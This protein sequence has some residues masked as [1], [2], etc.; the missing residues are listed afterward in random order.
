M[1]VYHQ[2]HSKKYP[3]SS[4][5]RLLHLTI[6]STSSFLYDKN[7]FIWNNP[8]ELDLLHMKKSPFL[9]TMNENYFLK[10]LPCIRRLYTV[11]NSICPNIYRIHC[12]DSLRVLHE[13]ICLIKEYLH[14][15][16]P[17]TI[18]INDLLSNEKLLDDFINQLRFSPSYHSYRNIHTPIRR[19]EIRCFGQ[20]IE[21]KDSNNQLNE[22]TLFCFE[23]ISTKDNEFL[24]PIDVVILDSNDQYV[25]NDIQYINTYDRGYTKL[26][27]CSYKPITQSGIYK[28]SFHYNHLPI[29]TD[30]FTVF[31]R[32]SHEN[33][34]DKKKTTD[35]QGNFLLGLYLKTEI[36]L[37]ETYLFQALLP[38]K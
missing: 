30:P 35:G 38:F 10:V 7:D 20:G 18:K 26:F 5:S 33:K 36:L 32:N 9:S 12:S 25:T 6:P 11:F 8:T 15:H 22:K 17:S 31:I 21:T 28:I 3:N 4:S 27:S 1:G 29:T 2:H 19:P 24:L 14:I 23:I 16:P 34:Q 37:M 13:L